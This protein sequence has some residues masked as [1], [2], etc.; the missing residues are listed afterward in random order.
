MTNPFESDLRKIAYHLACENA[1]EDSIKFSITRT[2]EEVKEEAER[3]YHNLINN[4][5]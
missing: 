4:S 2:D 3:I 1:K 5:K